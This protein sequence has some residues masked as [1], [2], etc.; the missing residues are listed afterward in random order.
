MG[1]ASAFSA[2][3]RAAEEREAAAANAMAD[4]E[5]ML[6]VWGFKGLT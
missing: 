3:K 4:L 6:G 2:A 1:V 5:K